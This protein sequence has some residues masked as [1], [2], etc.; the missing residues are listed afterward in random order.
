MSEPA[1][2]AVHTRSCTFLLDAVGVCRFIVSR[3]GV[4]PADIRGAVGS[5]FVASMHP[6]LE[7]L[8]AGELVVGAVAL[9]TKLDPETG[10]MVLL[11]TGTIVH[12][13]ERGRAATAPVHASGSWPALSDDSLDLGSGPPLSLRPAPSVRGG[14]TVPPPSWAIGTGDFEEVAAP[15]S[16]GT[17]TLTLPLIRAE[18]A[19]KLP[20][21]R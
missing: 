5:Q 4:V 12:V 19:R 15:D 14:D 17:V 13:E 7:G 1:T 2:Y 3:T 20:P 16:G 6:E 11:R 18:G 9:F 21:S 10:R 8:L